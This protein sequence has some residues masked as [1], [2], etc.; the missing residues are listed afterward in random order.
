MWATSA[1]WRCPHCPHLYYNYPTPRRNGDNASD[2]GSI[3]HCVGTADPWMLGA[4]TNVQTKVIFGIGRRDAEYFAKLTG[5][6][7][8]EAVKRDPK[9]ET[10]HEQIS[11]LLSSRNRWLGRLCSLS[12]GA[13]WPGRIAW[14]PSS[15]LSSFRLGP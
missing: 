8:A 15:D 5:R 9:R 6:L 7:D 4:L 14:L 11:P 12:S 1:V 3:T 13:S 10:Q 2:L